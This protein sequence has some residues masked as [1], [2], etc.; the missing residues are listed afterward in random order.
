MRSIQQNELKFHPTMTSRTENESKRIFQN[1]VLTFK[2]I[3]GAIV[4]FVLGVITPPAYRNAIWRDSFTI[5]Q[6]R[7]SSLLLQ[8]NIVCSEESLQDFIHDQPLQ[9]FHIFCFENGHK[10][11]VKVT[12]YA[13][14]TRSK[15]SKLGT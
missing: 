4:F 6:V 3:I 9:G 2:S 11:Q 10:S 7:N 12:A 15:K 8:D 1:E 13:E 14:A 5:S